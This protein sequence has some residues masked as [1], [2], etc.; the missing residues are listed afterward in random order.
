[1]RVGEVDA[2][3]V[4]AQ[5]EPPVELAR[6]LPLLARPRL[7]ARHDD[8]ALVGE[9][10][11]AR[12]VER[13]EHQAAVGPLAAQRG[14]HLAQDLVDPVDVLGVADGDVEYG[15]GVVLRHVRH[16]AD[17]AV[18]DGVHVAVVVAQRH[19]PDRDRLHHPGAVAEPDHVADPDR[20]AQQDEQAGRQVLDQLLRA[21]ADREAHD[22]GTGE[23]RRRIHAHRGQQVPAH[24]EHRRG[25]RQV[26]DDVRERAG[27]VVVD[28]VAL[29]VRGRDVARGHPVDGV[30]EQ[31]RQ[32]RGGRQA[33]AAGD[34]LPARARAEPAPD[35]DAPGLQDHARGDRCAR[36]AQRRGGEPAPGRGRGRLGLAALGAL[37]H[38]GRAT[39]QER[40][41]QGD[42]ERAQRR[43]AKM[44]TSAPRVRTSWP[45]GI[46][47]AQTRYWSTTQPAR[48]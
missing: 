43:Q 2:E 14:V 24:H 11:Q 35:V 32:R 31:A 8:H 6:H 48:R 9:R 23:E 45:P 29:G 44:V 30:P 5:L 28:Q 22:A 10:V 41:V 33:G 13:L 39:G 17:R 3:L 15:E 34:D 18:R 7:A 47:S 12:Q 46:R 21:E 27:P 38:H 4:E 36:Q 42:V 16:D 1:V 19:R 37:G 26:A 25:E 20:V 40:A